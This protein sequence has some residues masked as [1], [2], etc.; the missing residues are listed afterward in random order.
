MNDKNYHHG[1]LR[2]ELIEKGIEILNAEGYA[3]LSLRKVAKACDVSHA[4]PY[5][6]FK[7]KDE[8]LLAMHQHVESEF[9]RV[10]RQAAV[11]NADGDPLM[12]QGIAYIRF[13]TQ[14]PA[15]FSFMVNLDNVGIVISRDNIHSNYLPFDLFRDEALR[16]MAKW[17]VPPE[18]Q[19]DM[20]AAMWAIVHGVTSMATMKSIS[21]DGDWCVLVEEIMH[22]K[23]C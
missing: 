21:Y 2:E 10:L 13:F 12:A 5:N 9:A 22:G 6:H 8:L 4:A 16:S 7:D 14:N 11:D 17:G 18:E 20:L 19:P 1:N 15:Y 23:L 3:N